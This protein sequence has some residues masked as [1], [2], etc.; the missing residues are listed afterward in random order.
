MMGEEAG[1]PDEKTATSVHML[2]SAAD[3]LAADV[4]AAAAAYKSN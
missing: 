4:L 3:M 1:S 2:A